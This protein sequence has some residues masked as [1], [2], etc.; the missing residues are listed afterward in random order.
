MVIAAT[1]TEDIVS[2]ISIRAIRLNRTA[3]PISVTPSCSRSV[4]SGLTA[5]NIMLVKS[6]LGE[7]IIIGVMDHY[8]CVRNVTQP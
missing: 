2:T 7:A 5:Q 3:L 4:L 8:W 1:T 6:H